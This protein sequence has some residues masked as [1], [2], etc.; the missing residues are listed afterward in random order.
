MKKCHSMQVKQYY[1]FKKHIIWNTI[2]KHLKKFFE[3]MSPSPHLIKDLLNETIFGAE[4]LFHVFFLA[5]F[6]LF[7]TSAIYFLFNFPRA[8]KGKTWIRVLRAAETCTWVMAIS[9]LRRLLIVLLDT[10]E[11]YSTRDDKS[12]LLLLV[13][14]NLY[15]WPLK[16]TLLPKIGC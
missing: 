6:I 12:T 3:V 9:K 16:R 15:H 14:I 7:H 4:L 11:K 5:L 10:C 1:F 8:V 2:N 13:I